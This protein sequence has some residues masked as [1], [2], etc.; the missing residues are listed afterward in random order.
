MIPKVHSVTCVG[1]Q[2]H[3][4][5]IEVDDSLGLPKIIIIGLPDQAIKESKD[6]IRSAITSSGFKLPS[7]SYTVNLAPADIKKEGPG[8]D[9]PIA[10]GFLAKLRYIDN[11]CLEPYAFVGELALDGSL[12]PIHS[13]LSMALGL[14][15]ANKILIVPREN[16]REATLQNEVHIIPAKDLRD[17]V[18][19]ITNPAGLSQR[20]VKTPSHDIKQKYAIDF[21]DIKGQSCAKRALEIAVSGAHNILM[22]WTEYQLRGETCLYRCL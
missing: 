21:E 20:T 7:K 18:E 10:I 6:R 12:R 15:G 3:S 19:I 17:V 16:F 1:I 2:S 11:V 9:L 14:K 8:F 5:V 4:I 13:T 22:M